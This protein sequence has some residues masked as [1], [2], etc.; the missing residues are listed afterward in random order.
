MVHKYKNTVKILVIDFFGPKN[1]FQPIKN[2]R[3]SLKKESLAVAFVLVCLSLSLL[4]CLD[5][6][7]SRRALFESSYVGQRI[8]WFFEGAQV[9]AGEGQG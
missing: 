6:C 1:H 3:M 9:L 7:S 2:E 5:L 4:F 8:V